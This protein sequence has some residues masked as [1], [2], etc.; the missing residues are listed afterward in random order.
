MNPVVE[1]KKPWR[2]PRFFRF[3]RSM[4]ATQFILFDGCSIAPLGICV[5]ISGKR[6]VSEHETAPSSGQRT[7]LPRRLSALHMT[8]SQLPCILQSIRP[9][10]D[11]SPAGFACLPALAEPRKALCW[12]HL[13]VFRIPGRDAETIAM[14]RS[15]VFRREVMRSPSISTR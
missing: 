2:Q 11:S 12:A 8:Q 13:A 3:R 4:T 14:K 6:P 10:F 15:Q 1:S 9:S 7:S 5:Q